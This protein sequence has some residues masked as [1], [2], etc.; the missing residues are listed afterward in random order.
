MVEGNYEVKENGKI[1]QVVSKYYNYFFKKD[2]GFFARWGETLNDDP[3]YSPFGPEL[4][5]CE[6]TDICYGPKG[7][8]NVCSFCYKSNTPNGK[9]MSFETF[10][11]VFDSI[12]K[13][14]TQIAFGV[15]SQCITNPDVFKIMQYSRDNGV[16]PNVTVANVS[17]EVADKIS[18]L[19]GAVAVSR[20]ED[21]ELCYDSVKK[22]I[23]RGMKQ[24]NIHL[25]I[26]QETLETA[27]ETL[28]DYM[29]DLRLKNLNAIIFLSLKQ[30]GRGEK[31]TPLTQDQFDKLTEFCLKNNIPI[32]F[33]SC[34]VPKLTNTLSNYPKIKADVEKYI[35]PCESGCFSW[36]CNTEGTFFP[37]SFV[38]GEGEWENGIN[39][40]EVNDFI[41]DVWYNEKVKEFRNKLLCNNKKCPM[42]NI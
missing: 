20:Y 7:D 26:S 15:D 42:F 2:N 36:Y 30:K 4:I 25:M 16:I 23:D 37:C 28:F 12:P 11:K 40:D 32:G 19:C 17:D 27:Y 41:N 29:Y 6:V 21:K 5:D 18:N 1:K 38:E 14:V 8:G 9:Y 24:T 33:D 35:E 3:D 31:Y 10:K 22:F 39:I 34:S 13:T